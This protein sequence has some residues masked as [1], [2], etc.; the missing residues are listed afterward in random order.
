MSHAHGMVKFSD[1]TVGFYEYDGTSDV[2]CTSV[3][4]TSEEVSRDW[5][6]PANRA[7][8][9]CG[10][11]SEP[12]EI[13]TYYGSGFHWNGKACRACLAITDGIMPY[14]CDDDVGLTDGIPSWANAKGQG[15]PAENAL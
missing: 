4:A 5:R 8:C 2:V 1:G 13:M 6:S 7:E 15:T 12:V 9:T 3:K 14:D 10:N 11:E